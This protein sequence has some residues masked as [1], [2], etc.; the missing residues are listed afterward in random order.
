MKGKNIQRIISIVC[1]FAIIFTHS[2]IVANAA[3]VSHIIQAQTNEHILLDS[4]DGFE[5]HEVTAK[6]RVGYNIAIP[7]PNKNVIKIG[8]DPRNVSCRGNDAYYIA[9]GW[10]IK[11]PYFSESMF[12]SEDGYSYVI[13]SKAALLTESTVLLDYPVTHSLRSNAENSKGTSAEICFEE[14]YGEK[15]YYSKGNIT[16][17]I[18]TF[19]ENTNYLY[20][21][22]RLSEIVY[23]D[24]AMVSISYATEGQIKMTYNQNGISTVFARFII[25]KD[26]HGYNI[27]KNVI[28]TDG[29]NI[30]FEYLT[31]D[32]MLLLSAYNLHGKYNREFSYEHATDIS[33][34]AYIDTK[35][36]DGDKAFAEYEYD[37]KGLISK[38]SKSNAV[39]NYDYSVGLDGNLTVS[40]F[41]L[42]EGQATIYEDVYNKYGQLTKYTYPGN[43]LT[44]Q[45]DSTNRIIK[46]TENGVIADFTYNE[47][48]LPITA[49]WSNGKTYQYC[50]SEVGELTAANVIQ[51]GIVEEMLVE[52]MRQ[53]EDEIT[54]TARSSN[55]TV[56]YNINSDV[57]VLNWHEVYNVSQ[58][59]F[60]CYSYVA[61]WT[62]DI[63]NPGY[64]SGQLLTQPI[65]TDSLVKKY[66]E[67]DQEALGR[68]I[69][70]CGVNDT[71]N[72][73][74]WKIALKVRP[75]YDYHFMG[76]SYSTSSRP[77]H[78]EFKAGKGGP[79]M[80][81][82]NNKT[83]SQV[84]WDMYAPSASGNYVVSWSN[85][86]TSSLHYMIIQD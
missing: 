62:L 57:C 76:K 15:T 67:D 4:F 19:A 7:L 17:Y 64:F 51:N 32:N 37:S 13:N 70:D 61:G 39:E 8:F 44:L 23:S 52:T 33:R 9:D 43:V 40:V 82:L 60:N 59:S 2:I 14:P 84:T 56:E 47:Q 29:N 77:T 79:V 38:I 35:Y 27:L 78:W 68:D 45:Y 20:S 73:H 53:G 69:Y 50:Y 30:D 86:Y 12:Y 11:L 83:P 74:A 72:S 81:L 31:H 24:G 46:E 42:Y 18:D 71:H 28:V 6:G 34:V 36:F 66:T 58:S 22:G 65:V 41:K 1:L 80:R 55:V 48:G 54:N 26:S 49:E 5:S 25:E 75:A 63:F 21:N 10:Q 85:V 3:E 16:K